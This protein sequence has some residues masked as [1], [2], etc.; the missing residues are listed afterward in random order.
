M[1]RL[2]NATCYIP[3][4]AMLCQYCRSDRDC[5]NIL[6]TCNEVEEGY[7]V[8]EGKQDVGWMPKGLR[9]LL[10]INPT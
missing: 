3:S 6:E 8:R 2:K 4:L 10:Y 7:R 9:M 5:L 1:D